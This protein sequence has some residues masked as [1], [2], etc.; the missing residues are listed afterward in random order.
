MAVNQIH[1][2][3]WLVNTIHRAGRISLEEINQE[4][5]ESDIGDGKP[6]PRRTFHVWQAAVLDIF[7][8]IIENEGRGLYRYYIANEAE[9]TSGTICSWLLDSLTVSNMMINSKGIQ[10]RI[11]LERVP[12]ARA[13]LSVVVEALRHNNKIV[14]TYQTFSQTEPKVRTVMPYC[15]K[16]FKQRWYM[17]AQR[18]DKEKPSVYALDRVK[19]MQVLREETFELPADFDG[20]AYFAPYYGI[21][22][23]ESVERAEV[24]LRVTP[25]Q[26]KYLRALPLHHSQQ[27][28]ETTEEA[29]VFGYSLR[30]AFDFVQEIL[31]HGSEMEVLEPLWLREKIAAVIKEENNIYNG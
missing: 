6:I 13:F 17:L 16:L 23:D 2:Y 20:E 14:L 27:E 31:A 1:K 15:V 7:G 19:A 4:W 18:E 24:R 29:S 28:L 21:T 3:V 22:A 8:L 12:S 25:L 30:P 11:L 26:A 10:D 9:M 5:L